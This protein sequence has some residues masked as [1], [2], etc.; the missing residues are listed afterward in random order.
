MAKSTTKKYKE[1]D[2]EKIKR[3]TEDQVKSLSNKTN[4]LPFCYQLGKDILVGNYR[5]VYVD[6]KCW[7]VVDND[8]TLFDFFSRKD[9]IFYCIA[10]HKQDRTTADQIKQA[11]DRVARLEFEAIIYRARY[12]KAIERNDGFKEDY[13]SS[14]YL[15]T[16]DKLETVKKEL[17]KTLNLAKYI[18][19]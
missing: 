12:K 13:Y 6:D 4:E 19:E 18:K 11:D 2:L 7:R 10:L 8:V 17:K 1:F 5:V 16:M 9:A 14:R 15:D 3:F